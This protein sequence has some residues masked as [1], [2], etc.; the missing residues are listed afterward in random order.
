MIPN[1]HR[2]G[3]DANATVL[4]FEKILQAG[5]LEVIRGMLKGRNK[6]QY[7]P[8][9]LPAEQLDRLPQTPGVYYFHDQKGKVIYLGKAKNLHHR[10][11]SHFSNNTTAPHKPQ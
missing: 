9:H 8:I 3:G 5:G 4:L 11:R 2:G 6:E 7:L 10:V 1:R